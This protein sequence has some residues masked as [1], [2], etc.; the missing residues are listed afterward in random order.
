[1]CMA[2]EMFKCG[3]NEV[4]KLLC[5]LTFDFYLDTCFVDGEKT[6]RKWWDKGTSVETRG[7]SGHHMT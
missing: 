6:K 1:M 3:V 2:V 5:F 7:K 4:M